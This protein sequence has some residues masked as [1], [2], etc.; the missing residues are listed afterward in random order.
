[1][2]TSVASLVPPVPLLPPAAL[3]Q[4]L[5]AHSCLFV[6]RLPT[7]AELAAPPPDE[8][9]ASR[10]ENRLQLMAGQLFEELATLQHA[11]RLAQAGFPS[12]HVSRMGG[13]ASRCEYLDGRIQLAM[14]GTRLAGEVLSGSPTGAVLRNC[15]CV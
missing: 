3:P 11:T 12:D 14:I 7:P 4:P 8:A 13:L 6:D 5:R 10:T 15:A 9:A 1:M 2:P